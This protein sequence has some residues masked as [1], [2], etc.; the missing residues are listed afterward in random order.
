MMAEINNTIIREAIVD[1]VSNGNTVPDGMDMDAY[2]DATYDMDKLTDLIREACE[3]EDIAPVNLDP[4]VWVELLSSCDVGDMVR[5]DLF[6]TEDGRRFNVG[7]KAVETEDVENSDEFY[8]DTD[9]WL[10]VVLYVNQAMYG[11]T[12]R[13][14]QSTL[15]AL[16]DNF[17][18]DVKDH[19]RMRNDRQYRS[20]L[21]TDEGFLDLT[22][23]PLG[24]DGISEP[25]LDCTWYHDGKHELVKIPMV[26]SEA[27]V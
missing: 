1:Y 25:A 9:R 14:I 10:R 24:F 12:G 2:V 7:Y 15:A 26:I 16:A 8:V 5:V 3:D 19:S 18:K 17:A 27:H 6:D 13:V 11:Y 22:T 23:N 4:D 21:I 20:L